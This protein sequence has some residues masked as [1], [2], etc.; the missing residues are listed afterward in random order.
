VG[1]VAVGGRAEEEPVA[2][3]GERTSLA[4]LRAAALVVAVAAVSVATAWL[5]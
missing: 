3:A 2:G 1:V 5:V 4:R